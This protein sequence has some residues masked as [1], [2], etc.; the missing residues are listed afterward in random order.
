MNKR[1]LVK[2]AILA[3]AMVGAFGFATVGTSSEAEARRC[4]RGGYGGGFGG[5]WGYGAY[6]GGPRYYAPPVVYRNFYRGGGFGHYNGFYGGPAFYGNRG[7]GL[8][9]GF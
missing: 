2:R 4:Y 1:S 6:Y 7:F 8:T 9:I 3:V 5:G